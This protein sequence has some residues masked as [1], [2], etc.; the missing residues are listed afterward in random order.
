VA[1]I[2]DLLIPITVDAWRTFELDAAVTLGLP[3]TAWKPQTPERVLIEIDSR[4]LNLLGIVATEA[5]RGGFLTYARGAWLTLLASDTFGTERK[6]ATFASCLVTFMSSSSTPHVIPVGD[7]VIVKKTGTDIT[8]RVD[9]PFIIP[10]GPGGIIA[11]LV[12]VCETAGSSGTAIAGDI[13]EIQDALIDVAVVNTT[14]AV[15]IDEEPDED[16]R[17]RAR[18]ATGPLSPAGPEAAYEYIATTMLRADGQPVDVTKVKV[19]EDEDDGNVTAYYAS[20]SGPSVDVGL[21]M[22]PQPGDVIYETRRLVVPNGVKYQ[23]FPATALTLNIDYIAAVRST[24]LRELGLTTDEVKDIVA[25]YLASYIAS[26]DLPIEG[27][28]M[29]SVLPPY[30][31]ILPAQDIA[32]LIGEAVRL[33]SDIEAGVAGGKLL[34]AITVS[35]GDLLYEPGEVAVLGSIVADLVVY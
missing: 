33:N 16:L 15:G 11:D 27:F 25:N 5:I 20:P 13:A 34:Y 8:Y 10:S 35:S 19:T 2:T 6:A 31:G 21:N 23:G 24:I 9:G 28:P 4:S 14:T 32:D 30:V 7:R 3:T 17:A 22:N 1:D 26:R 29:V 12:A 18:L